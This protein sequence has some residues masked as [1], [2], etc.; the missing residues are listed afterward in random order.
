MRK[1]STALCS[2]ACVL[3]L[4]LHHTIGRHLIADDEVFSRVVRPWSLYTVPCVLLICLFTWV[5]AGR[6]A[7]TWAWPLLLVAYLAWAAVGRVVS[8]DLRTGEVRGHWYIVPT[9][10]HSLRPP[11]VEPKQYLCDARILA[12]GYW[13][14]LEYNETTASI[15][16][17]PA[18]A[19]RAAFEI[20]TALG[21]CR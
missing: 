12:H 6:P 17:G 3:T 15:W 7:R 4:L 20:G 10:S 16:A 11:D 14:D 1:L 2:A 18:I 5:V 19:A 9:D 13:L 21:R 8:V